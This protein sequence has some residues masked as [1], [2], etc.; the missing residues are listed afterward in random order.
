MYETSFV[1][2]C[3]VRLQGYDC[4]CTVREV[5]LFPEEPLVHCGL[6][7]GWYSNVYDKG[8]RSL[9]FRLYVVFW[10]RPNLSYLFNKIV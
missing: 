4:K 8:V 1:T 10:V 9:W 6:R 5:W 3:W 7:Q 2:G